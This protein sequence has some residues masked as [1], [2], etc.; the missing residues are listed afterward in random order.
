[1]NYFYLK[2]ILPRYLVYTLYIPTIKC[3]ITATFSKITLVV[4]GP[5]ILVSRA[6]A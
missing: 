6:C 2:L 3:Y 4:V 5:V 1:M